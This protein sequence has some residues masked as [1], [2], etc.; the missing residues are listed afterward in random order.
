MSTLE[1][2]AL[3]STHYISHTRGVSSFWWINES[4]TKVID[5]WEK[6]FHRGCRGGVVFLARLI[7]RGV[8]GVSSGKSVLRHPGWDTAQ[9]LRE[10]I[11]ENGQGCE[12]LLSETHLRD[13]P[14]TFCEYTPVRSTL[15]TKSHQTQTKKRLTF[16]LG[17]FEFS[18]FGLSTLSLANETR[19]CFF[20][21]TWNFEYSKS[22]SD[23]KDIYLLQV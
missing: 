20:R 8:R 11:I 18:M 3:D 7:V 1:E 6:D 4:W 12:I 16:F 22:K 19:S 9:C 14:V 17:I 2:T 21:R 23:L 10:Q 15:R 5:L 13:T